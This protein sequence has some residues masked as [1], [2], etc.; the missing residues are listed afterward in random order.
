MSEVEVKLL[1][2]G[3]PLTDEKEEGHCCENEDDNGFS[4]QWLIDTVVLPDLNSLDGG[5][6]G[7]DESEDGGLPPS[8]GLAGGLNF[9]GGLGAND[10]AGLMGFSAVG[11]GLSAMGMP[12]LGPSSGASSGF[13]AGLGSLDSIASMALGMVYPTIK[14]MFEASIRRVTVKV[15][16]SE[17]TSERTF[18]VGQYVTNPQQGGMLTGVGADAGAGMGGLLGGSGANT[19]TSTSTSISKGTTR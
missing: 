5:V 6:D 18:E 9:D 7:G 10:G 19:S 16:W 17:G 12:G 8:R 4:C 14:P 11:N 2:D 1:H 3:F 15:K 13:G